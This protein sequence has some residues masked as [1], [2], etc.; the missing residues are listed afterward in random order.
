M[1]ACLRARACRIAKLNP[2]R[3]GYPGSAQ[4]G[5]SMSASPQNSNRDTK[6]EQKEGMKEEEKKER[7]E[8]K[9]KEKKKESWTDF[10]YNPRSGEFLGRTCSSWGEFCRRM[11]PNTAHIRLRSCV[12][13]RGFA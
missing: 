11:E 6:E 10:I 5:S 12:R 1:F 9:E 7:K 2:L 4:S 13:V 3:V 8:K